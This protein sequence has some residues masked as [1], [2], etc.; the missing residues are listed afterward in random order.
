MSLGLQC[1]LMSNKP[2]HYQLEHVD[3][4]KDSYVS[5]SCGNNCKTKLTESLKQSQ[6]L[7]IVVSVEYITFSGQTSFIMLKAETSQTLI[8]I[9]IRESLKM[10]FGVRQASLL[11]LLHF[12]IEMRPNH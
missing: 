6:F 7:G 8:E 4:V 1:G 10:N 2:T 12:L 11:G 3:Y 5:N 9:E